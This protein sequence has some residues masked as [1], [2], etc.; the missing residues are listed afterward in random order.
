MV[1]LHFVY[2]APCRSVALSKLGRPDLSASDILRA[3]SAGYPKENAH[4]LLQRLVKCREEQSDE[5]GVKDALKELEKSLK[6]STLSSKKK[7]EIVMD[8]RQSLFAVKRAKGQRSDTYLN[9]GSCAKDPDPKC[10]EEEFFQTC[11]DI[12]K[13][14]PDIPCASAALRMERDPVRGRYAVA[15]R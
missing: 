6:D 12:R 15:A 2:F 14:S 3:L 13:P 5:Q 7:N 8:A 4:R 10:Q 1:N 11:L 9:L